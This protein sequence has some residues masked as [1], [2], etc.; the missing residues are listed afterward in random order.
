MTASTRY[1]S[2]SRTA[3]RRLA[4]VN[5][6]EKEH[7]SLD[8][9]SAVALAFCAFWMARHGSANPQ[10]AVIIRRA[11]QLLAEHLSQTDGDG[12]GVERQAFLQAAAGSGSALTLTQARARIEA[13][14]EA[15]ARQPMADWR[16]ALFSQQQRQDTAD[17]LHR[18][19]ASMAQHEAAG[20]F[21]QRRNKAGQ[22]IT[23]PA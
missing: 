19:E 11:L 7:A 4:A 10:P 12:I 5:S 21:E 15:P 2:P 1:V 23:L 3:A 18:L 13:H 16:D 20:L 22:F 17:M 14:I 9:R 6:I 8:A